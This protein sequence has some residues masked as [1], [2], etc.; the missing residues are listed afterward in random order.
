MM[1]PYTID[2]NGIWPVGDRQII[3]VIKRKNG[4]AIVKP[5]RRAIKIMPNYKQAIARA[6]ILAQNQKTKLVVHRE[7]GTVAESVSYQEVDAV[8]RRIAQ[9]FNPLT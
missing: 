4:W 5:G 6:R 7:D 8:G 9:Y 3:H 2:P 1:K